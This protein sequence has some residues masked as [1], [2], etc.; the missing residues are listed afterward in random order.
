MM[1]VIIL[2]MTVYPGGAGAGLVEASVAADAEAEPVAAAAIEAMG[3]K[4]TRL[5]LLGEADELDYA[6]SG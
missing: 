5:L 4:L 2:L 3:S 6:E 1:G